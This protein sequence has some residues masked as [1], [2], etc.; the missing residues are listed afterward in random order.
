MKKIF[1]LLFVLIVAGILVL[2]LCFDK[3]I[4]FVAEHIGSKATKTAVI[5]QSVNVSLCKGLIELKEISIGNPK[6]YKTE[7][8]FT[9]SSIQIN[10]IPK[11]IFSKIVKINKILVDNSEIYY[12]KNKKGSG[13][14]DEILKNIDEFI[15]SS[16]SAKVQKTSSNKL[17]SRQ[18]II[19]ENF[20]MKGTKVYVYSKAIKDDHIEVYMPDINLKNIGGKSGITIKEAGDILISNISVNLTKTVT[21][22]LIKLPSTFGG[23]A[24]DAPGRIFEGF[25]KAIQKLD[26]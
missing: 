21:H 12:E 6:N 10:F 18:K 24:K 13:N 16:D 9:I 1:M 5:F 22:I 14:I 15:G 17:G 8:A 26:R 3:T 11:S 23:A 2:S 7:S 20:N 19:I 4:K 25:Y